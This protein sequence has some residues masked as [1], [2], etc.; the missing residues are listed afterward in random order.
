MFNIIYSAVIQFSRVYINKIEFV[1]RSDFQ[2]DWFYHVV[3]LVRTCKKSRWEVFYIIFLCNF[4]RFLQSFQITIL[5]SYLFILYGIIQ[6]HFFILGFVVPWGFFLN[7]FYPLNL[8]VFFPRVI[9]RYVFAARID[10]GIVPKA[11]D[12][13][14]RKKRK[15]RYCWCTARCTTCM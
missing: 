14:I 7:R 10:V 9:P 5:T 13:E 3:L 6:P 11:Y 2:C 1:F 12:L 4:C 15:C 8:H